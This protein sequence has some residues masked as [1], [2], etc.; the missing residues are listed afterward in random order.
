[1]DNF[2]YLETARRDAL[3][4]ARRDTL[5]LF[6]CYCGIEECKPGYSYGPAIR[7]QYLIHYVLDGEGTY[8]VN[9]KTY[10]LK[11]NQ[12]FLICPNVITFYKA[13]T[14]NPWTYIWIGFDGIK[15]STYL[16][17]ANLHKDNLIFEY[18]EDDALKEY[19]LDMLKHNT[20]NYGDELRIQGLLY[21]FLSRLIHTAPP[22]LQPKDKASKLYIVKSIEFIEKNCS[23]N[24]KITDIA[25]YVGLNRSYLTSLFKSNLNM[26]PQAFL[27]NFR[28]DKACELLGNVELSIGDVARSVGYTD[29]LAFSK[30]FKKSKGMSP[31][32]YRSKIT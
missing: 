17:Y 21:L 25:H 27:L 20:L 28:M 12:G 16:K 11:K 4:L 10:K 6:V 15:A 18:D 13:D 14:E 1:M 30:V 23:N 3:D 5:D 22:Y 29:A 32:E 7:S 8:Y 24:I 31:R 26:S 9:N 2:K 19:I